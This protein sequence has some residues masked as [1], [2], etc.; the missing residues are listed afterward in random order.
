VGIAGDKGSWERPLERGDVCE[1]APLLVSCDRGKGDARC[2][3]DH[4]LD[5]H[6]KV[7]I[8]LTRRPDGVVSA[9]ATVLPYKLLAPRPR[10]VPAGTHHGIA[11]P[12]GPTRR[13]DYV[14]GADGWHEVT[15]S[16]PAVAK[17]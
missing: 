12:C 13:A 1:G 15:A 7:T 2:S 17:P 4:A 16:P 6:W 11:S 14:K 8:D 10:R 3:K 9:S 5:Q